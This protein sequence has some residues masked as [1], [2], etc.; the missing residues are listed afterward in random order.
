MDRVAF[1]NPFDSPLVWILRDIVSLSD[2]FARPV[3]PISPVTKLAKRL[4]EVVLY[5]ILVQ[6]T[7]PSKVLA[8]PYQ[9]LL[10]LLVL[11]L[12][13]FPVSYPV[14]RD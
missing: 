2:H 10:S 1:Y 7:Q 11:D 13:A 6:M 5:S 14:S 9:V 12:T 4:L 8:N 3:S